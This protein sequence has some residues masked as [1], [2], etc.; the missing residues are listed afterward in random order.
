MEASTTEQ[1]PPP[2]AAPPVRAARPHAAPLAV[3]ATSG[4]SSLPF[5]PVS[6]G[7]FVPEGRPPAASQD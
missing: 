2:P 6:P 1:Q 3:I 7:V 5:G 4:Q